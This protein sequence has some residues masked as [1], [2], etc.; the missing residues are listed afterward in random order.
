[1]TIG[2]IE[3]MPR[4]TRLHAPWR[5]FWVAL[6]VRVAY[7]TLAH[8]YRFRPDGDHFLFGFEMARTA[9]ALATG[10]GFA[11][12]FMDLALRHTGPSAWMPPLYP[13]LIALAFKLFGVYTLKSAWVVLTLNS[14]FSA[15]TVLAVY[16]IGARCFDAYGHGKNVAAWSAWIWALHPA[17]MQFAVRWVWDMSLT[18]MLFA[19]VLVLALRMRGIGERESGAERQTITRW[20]LFGALWG[21]IALSNSTLLLFLPVCGVWVL[22]GA[23]RKLPAL[24]RAVISGAVF[25]AMITPWIWRNYHVF[26]VLVPFRSNFG[27]ELDRG[28]NAEASG[29]PWGITVSSEK[30]TRHYVQV[31]EVEFVRERGARAKEWIGAHPKAFLVLSLKRLYFF[32]AGVPQS[33]DRGWWVEFFRELN[34]C[35]LSVTGLLGLG[36][37]MRQRVPAAGLF[38]CSFLLLPVTYYFV[39]AGARFRH[40]LEPLIAILSV[41]LFQ[42][43]ELRWRKREREG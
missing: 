38:A 26:H 34:Y 17:A 9:R 35:S 20:L 30:D 23:Q 24:S 39:T 33:P 6:A 31:G 36:L 40:P 11:D 10:H 29:F 13:L 41:Y 28:N 21:L 18:A 19:W 14:V 4:E 25:L 22:W 8:T 43:A 2:T 3:K 5:I 32:W 7:M 15:S 42:S 12:P 27:A 37:A 16:E 1:L